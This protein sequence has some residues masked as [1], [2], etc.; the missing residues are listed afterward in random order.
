MSVPSHRITLNKEARKDIQAWYGFAT[1]FNG[2]S[3]LL[4]NR[5]LSNSHLHLHTDAAGSCGYAAIF[6]SHWF[7]GKWSEFH[8]SLHITFQEMLPIVIAFEI[9][10]A[11]LT[12]K[13][14]VLHSDNM[15][16]VH[17]LN[18]HTS[19]DVNIMC[20][21]RRFVLCCMHYNILTKAVHIQ[22][23]LNTLPDLLS[24]FQEEE[25]HRLAPDMD[26]WHTPIPLCL[27][28]ELKL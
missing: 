1:S 12:N 6:G 7:M 22:G 11:V 4:E 8:S 17:I 28:E 15:A 19:K 14:I 2:R 13:C 10:G 24:R 5:W 16:V 20:L 27:K 23:K 9:W 3:L 26:R 18:T 21:V 25:F